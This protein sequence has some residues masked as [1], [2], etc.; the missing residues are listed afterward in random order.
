MP[1]SL[2][3]HSPDAFRFSKRIFGNLAY[4]MGGKAAAG[5]VSLIYMIIA[6]RVLGPESYG[7]L[8]LVHAFAMTIGGVIALPGWHGLVRYGVRFLGDGNPGHLAKLASWL[9]LV[10]LAGGVAAMLV[11]AMLAPVVGPRL[12]WT[13]EA[14]HWFPLYSLAVLASVRGTPGGYLQLVRRFDLIGLH[15]L[16]TPAI[17][18]FGSCAAAILGWGLTG[19]LAVWLVAA[20][21]EGIALWGI[22]YAVAPKNE[23]ARLTFLGLASVPHDNEGLI[24]FSL[25][26]NADLAVGGFSG[27]VTPLILGWA[28]GPAGTALFSIAQ[29]VT[30]IFVQPAQMLGQAAYAELVRIV[31]GTGNRAAVRRALFQNV[32][33]AL[34]IALP[35]MLGLA[36]F[37]RQVVE[38]VAG[39]DYAAAA[40][41]LTWLCVARAVALTG[42][43]TNAA[44]TALGHPGVSLLVNMTTGA[45]F[46]AVLPAFVSHFGFVGAGIHALVQSVIAMIVLGAGL[47]WFTRASTPDQVR[48]QG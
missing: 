41:V 17:R 19:F 20:I 46:V 12:G 30:I 7:V 35:I 47:F 9:G 15:G 26:A 48:N 10:E 36:I 43:P 24:R 44:L 33:L 34:L 29:R 32:G 6:A 23:R 42:P 27:W 3:E 37:S 25:T 21:A 16:I 28:L 45:M 14:Q 2:N 13:A 22:A 39:P 8:V 38:L 11:A 1:E 5:V 31:H 40:P 18:L 4:L